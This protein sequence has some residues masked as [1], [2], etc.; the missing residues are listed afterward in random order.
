MKTIQSIQELKEINDTFNQL[1]TT[2]DVIIKQNTDY[3]T[4]YTKHQSKSFKPSESKEQT[5]SLLD[6]LDDLHQ[7]NTIGNESLKQFIETLEKTIESMKE[8]VESTRKDNKQYIQMKTTLIN[9]ITQSY[10]QEQNEEL[11]ANPSNKK[12]IKEKYKLI[13]ES[14]KKYITSDNKEEI[15]EILTENE[16]DTLEQWIGKNC[17]EIVFDST[18]DSNKQFNNKLE[19]KKQLVFLIEDEDEELFGFYFNPTIELK[20]SKNYYYE[21]IW[22][23]DKCFEFNLRES[24]NRDDPLEEPMQFEIIEHGKGGLKLPL[25]SDGG[26]NFGDIQ[27]SPNGNCFVSQCD[28][29]VNYHGY[30]CGLCGKAI[31]EWDEEVDSD[32]TFV[33]VRV[34]VIQMK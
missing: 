4:N 31:R 9:S 19:G 33:P 14:F 34:V 5:E 7:R 22:C 15:E 6:I 23:D 32:N 13:E 30:D 12:E 11:K 21:Q 10:K 28:E 3:I 18:K 24:E 1:K 26:F 25:K 20:K 17:S 29:I 8:V 2:I 16:I 27:F